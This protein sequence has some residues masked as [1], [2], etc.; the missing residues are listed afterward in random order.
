MKL[1][2][3]GTME[4]TAS[5]KTIKATSG[6]FKVARYSFFDLLRSRWMLIY[7]AFFVALGGGLLYF[8]GDSAQAALSILNVVILMVPLIC[9]MLSLSYY[10]YTRDFIELILTQPIGRSSVFLGHYLG[11]AL[12]LTGSFVLGTAWPF[13]IAGFRTRV[14]WPVVLSLLLAGALVSLIFSALAFWLGLLHEERVRALGLTLFIWLVFTIIYDA[15]LLLFIM[16]AQAYPLERALIALSL[17]N[18]VDLTRIFVLLQLDAAAL[19]GYTGA[20]FKRFLGSNLGVIISLASLLLWVIIPV[21][22]GLR[23]F[24]RKNF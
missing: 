13:V 22:L 6:F 17:L 9:L 14:D 19:M 16:M 23:A 8:G 15:G 7:T 3:P 11:V 20:I 18:P 2:I 5:S 12:P 4:S 21:A 10:Y 1:A 24:R